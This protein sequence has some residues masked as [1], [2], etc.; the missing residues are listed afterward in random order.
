VFFFLTAIFFFSIQMGCSRHNAMI[1]TSSPTPPRDI[2]EVLANHVDEWMA[3]PG[4]V[5]V[6]VGLMDDEKTPCLKIMLAEKDT[7]LERS[8][9]RQIE[10]YPVLTEVSGLIKP[11]DR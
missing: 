5:G 3:M 11:M 6:Y 2:N 1:E 9:P 10:S 4:V 8:L 7:K